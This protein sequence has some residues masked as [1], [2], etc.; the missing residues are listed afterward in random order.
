M[1]GRDAHLMTTELADWWLERTGEEP[2]DGRQGRSARA[3][4]YLVAEFLA[5]YPKL[6]LDDLVLT[7]N[8]DQQW[9]KKQ[10][11]TDEERVAVC[12]LSSHTKKK[13]ILWVHPRVGWF[14][15]THG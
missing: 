8:Q 10:I 6:E 3:A 12:I 1:N 5:R 7:E 2:G 13:R 9:P 15:K 11:R 14:S 4:L